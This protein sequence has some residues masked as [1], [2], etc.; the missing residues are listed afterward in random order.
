MVPAIKVVSVRQKH[1]VFGRCEDQ[2]INPSL[3]GHHLRCCLQSRYHISHS[4]S[5]LFDI[6]VCV[7]L[8]WSQRCSHIAEGYSSLTTVPGPR[9]DAVLR[10]AQGFGHEIE[11]K[12]LAT[13][14]QGNVAKFGCPT[15]QTPGTGLYDNLQKYNLPYPEAVFDINY[16]MMDHKPFCSLAQD[17]Y[18][19]IHYRPNAAHYFLQ[20]LNLEGKLQKVY[21]QN[22]DGL[23]RLA[24]IPNE[25]LMEAHGTFS[26]ASCTLC[27]TKH[28]AIKVKKALFTGEGIIKCESGK[29]KGKVKPDI[30]F[31]GENLP[32]DFWNF[33]TEVFFTDML[34]V[35]GTSLE[36]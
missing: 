29:C 33:K 5:Y 14:G 12:Y 6:P 21:T 36:V 18:P 13:R 26:T 20:L 4:M 35:I 17:L 25:K 2:I 34:L 10:S 11:T 8:S 7:V 30:V 16:F 15:I 19:G 27:G 23:E 32:H 24:G 3:K 9:V 31:F 1:H 22:I 28:D